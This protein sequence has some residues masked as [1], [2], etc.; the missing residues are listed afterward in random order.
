M[1]TVIKNG[2]IVT[3]T[4]T[5]KSDMAIEKGIIAK[6]SDCIVPTSQDSVID[7]EGK[8]VL[9]GGIDPHAHLAIS[10]TVDDFESGTRAAASGGIT[11]I[12]NFTDPTPDQGSFL[13]DLKKWKQKAEHSIIDYGFHSIINRCDDA[14]LDEIAQLPENGVTSIKLF[15][16]YRGTNMVNDTD[17]FHL[18]KKASEAGMV[19]NVH[20]EHGDIIDLLIEEQRRKGNTA[21]IYHAYTRPA[22]LEAEAV[23]RV[24]TIAELLQAPV[25]IVHVSSKEALVEVQRAKER[26]VNVYG[27][28]CPHYLLLD[29]DYLKRDRPEAV[30]YIC[31]PPLRTKKDQS[32]LWKGLQTSALS[33]IGSDHASHPYKN[34]KTRGIDDF[35][36]APNGLPSI[37]N[38]YPLLYHFGVHE[39]RISLQTFAKVISLNAAK[40]FGLYPKKGIIQVGSDADLVLLDPNRTTLISEKSQHQK[41][42]YNVYEGFETK[43][44]IT[45]VLSRG[46]VI[47]KDHHIVGEPGRGE[48]LH[49]KKH[50]SFDPRG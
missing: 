18:M 2:I 36:K 47:V 44:T 10:G 13:D 32:A 48:F 12:I 24:L 6:L 5:F 37:E 31:S 21:P 38:I 29:E 9:P 46:D 45:H 34:G 20:A 35:T 49:R 1:A 40:I 19:T 27:E 39:K 43:G 23:N 25:Y 4:D 16:A 30:K 42:E 26:G 33:V 28:T 17:L 22:L 15:M 41:T 8:Y 3:P 11:S 14:V 7:A 50:T